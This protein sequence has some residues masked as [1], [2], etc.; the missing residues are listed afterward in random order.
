M[1][2]KSVQ[3]EHIFK[4]KKL[5]ALHVHH[6]VKYI[7][8]NTKRTRTSIVTHLSFSLISSQP[9][10]C[11]MCGKED[12]EQGKYN[13][14]GRRTLYQ[15]TQS[16]YIENTSNLWFTTRSLPLQ[17]WSELWSWQQQM[18]KRMRRQ[19]KERT[20]SLTLWDQPSG[21]V[22]RGKELL[23]QT[24]FSLKPGLFLRRKQYMYK[25][26]DSTKFQGSKFSQITIFH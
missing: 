18:T 8:T 26:P 17:T 7:L 5:Y 9:V 15:T 25:S 13:E 22:W 14:N 1:H 6:T 16:L 23:S 2:W 11:L 20:V 4:A 24:Q 19:W 3:E 10:M 12:R 21:L